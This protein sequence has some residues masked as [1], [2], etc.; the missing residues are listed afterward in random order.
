MVSPLNEGSKGTGRPGMV[1]PDSSLIHAGTLI[2]CKVHSVKGREWNCHQEAVC[3]P[4]SCR[5]DPSSG[6]WSRRGARE[7]S[8]NSIRTHHLEGFTFQR[9]AIVERSSQGPLCWAFVPT[10]LGHSCRQPFRGHQRS[11]RGRDRDTLSHHPVTLRT[12]PS[13]TESRVWAHE[14]RLCFPAREAELPPEG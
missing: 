9:L 8:C 14:R 12:C 10:D 6:G 3:Q 13:S 11:Q 2:G 4:L 1:M 5:K 7:G